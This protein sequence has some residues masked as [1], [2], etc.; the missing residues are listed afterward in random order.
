MKHFKILLKIL[1]PDWLISW[2][3][4]PIQWNNPTSEP[5]ANINLNY[6][7]RTRVVKNILND[8]PHISE[9]ASKSKEVNHWINKKPSQL[10]SRRDCYNPVIEQ[11]QVACQSYSINKNKEMRLAP[12]KP[13]NLWK[14]EAKMLKRTNK[15][16]SWFIGWNSWNL[17]LI[18]CINSPLLPRLHFTVILHVGLHVF[19]QLLQEKTPPKKQTRLRSCSHGSISPDST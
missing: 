5:I 2:R 3:G 6:I 12:Q 13:E 10:K 19:R 16:C 9:L 7:F 11:P 14:T 17:S 4:I 18:C 8:E 1:N 15:E